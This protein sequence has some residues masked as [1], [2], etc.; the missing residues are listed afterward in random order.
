MQDSSGEI[1]SGTKL[2]KTLV[3]YLNNLQK[4]PGLDEEESNNLDIPEL[5]LDDKTCS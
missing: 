3:E 4:G 1:V 5:Q 2:Q